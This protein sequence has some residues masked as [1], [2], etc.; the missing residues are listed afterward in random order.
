MTTIILILA[1]VAAVSFVFEGIVMPT[2]RLRLRFQLF[3][4][5]D[6]LREIRS[7]DNREAVDILHDCAN[8]AINMLHT[9]TLTMAVRCRLKS[10]SPSGRAA[11]AEH[12]RILQQ[13]SD[14]RVRRLDVQVK[15][16][17]AQTMFAN[18]FGLMIVAFPLVVVGHGY[19]TIRDSLNA[20]L[21]AP[22]QIAA[23]CR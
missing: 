22:N 1:A 8:V 17:F 21:M 15:R 7:A 11:V 16:V 6:E 23:F 20:I 19:Q 4:I 5:R 3:R 18:S 13:C 14:S 2:V 10:E 9:I 12:D